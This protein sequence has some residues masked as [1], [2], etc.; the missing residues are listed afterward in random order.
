M[1]WGV[2]DE[3][4]KKRFLISKW[5]IFFENIPQTYF[6]VKKDTIIKI[7]QN[8]INEKWEVVIEIPSKKIKF[9]QKIYSFELNIK[10]QKTI[11]SLISGIDKIE[12][13]IFQT[14]EILYK[15]NFS[16]V[17]LKGNL[18]TLKRQMW[19]E[20]EVLFDMTTRKLII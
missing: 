5:I 10:P 12:I 16:K 2:V 6:L 1:N 14:N 20:K 19:T 4:E 7:L 8:L 9:N 11:L 13:E 18:L 17:S 15:T 3:Q